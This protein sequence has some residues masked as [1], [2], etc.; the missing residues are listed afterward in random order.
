MGIRSAVCRPRLVYRPDAA[1]R[2]K[3]HPDEVYLVQNIY[4]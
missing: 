3:I 4:F 2:L 1:N